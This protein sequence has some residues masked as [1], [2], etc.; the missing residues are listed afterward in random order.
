[1]SVTASVRRLGTSAVGIVGVL[2]FAVGCSSASSGKPVVAGSHQAASS[3]AA[4]PTSPGSASVPVT[5][6]SSRP[7][8][9]PATLPV[10]LPALGGSQFCQDLSG[11]G[12]LAGIAGSSGNLDKALAAWDHLAAE[13]PAEIKADVQAVATYLHDAVKGTVNPADAEKFSGA[14]QHIGVYVATNCH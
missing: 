9:V 13:A 10:S 7:V 5:L 12:N 2:A 4:A 6:P 11:Q 8:S 3:I 14:A 1:M